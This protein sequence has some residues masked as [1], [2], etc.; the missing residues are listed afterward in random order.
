MAAGGDVRYL[1]SADGNE[2]RE[3]RQLHKSVI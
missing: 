3:K 2:I 1:M